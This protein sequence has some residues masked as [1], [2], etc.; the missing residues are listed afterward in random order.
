MNIILFGAPGA[1]KGTQAKKL[2]EE[3]GIP[4]I[5]TGDMFREAISNG[6]ELGKK[7]KG[8]MDQGELVPDDVTIGI[9]EERLA[10]SDCEKG[11]ILDGF[12]RTTHQA[13]ELTKI[14]GKQGKSIDKAVILE[15]KDSE[16]LERITGRR[17]SKKTG[18]IYHIKYNPPVDENEEDIYQREDDNE[19]AVVTRLKAYN[20][21][22]AP[23][24]DYYN[25]LGKT[26]IVDGVQEVNKITEDIIKIL[27]SL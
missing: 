5:S 27:N 10:K 25:N 16:I 1:G 26:V 22:T 3:Y 6:T 9:V 21:Q 2:V 7:A 23:L 14:L 13:E 15:V 11:F 17:I 8:Y 24:F 12:P 18:K 19:T 4:Q 20:E